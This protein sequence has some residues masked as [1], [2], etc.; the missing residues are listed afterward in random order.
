M[1][2]LIDELDSLRELLRHDQLGEL[3]LANWPLIEARP[4]KTPVEET[5]P[6]DTADTAEQPPQT[7]PISEVT[8]ELDT[9]PVLDDAIDD[10]EAILE[11]AEEEEDL[12]SR[13]E[14]LLLIDTLVERRIQRL[15]PTLIEQVIEELTLIYP[16]LLN[17]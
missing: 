15:R 10:D 17:E 2:K 6:V 13:A 4:A 3:D 14:L 7:A 11:D 8:P 9:I 5:T 12:P 16:G 1:S